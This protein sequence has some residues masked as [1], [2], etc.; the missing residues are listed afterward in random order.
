[1]V[2]GA[3]VREQGAARRARTASAQQLEVRAHILRRLTFGPFPGG[4]EASLAAHRST[5][6]VLDAMLAAKPAAFVPPASIDVPFKIND[7][8]VLSEDVLGNGELVKFWIKRMASDEV[9]IHDKMMWFWHTVFTT[10]GKTGTFLFLWRQLRTLH[11]NAMGNLR[12]LAKALV[13]DPAM[14]QFLNSD[15]SQIADPNENL[16]R[17]LMEL[18]MLGRGNYTEQD[19]R[20]AAIGLAGWGID[21]TADISRYLPVTAKPVATFLG[22]TGVFDPDSVVDQILAQPVAA[23]FVVRKMWHY[24]IGGPVDPKLVTEWSDAF[25]ASDYEIAPLVAAMV[26]SDAFL[27]SYRSRPRRGVEWL[28]AVLRILDPPPGRADNSLDFTQVDQLGQTPYFPP[29]VAGWPDDTEWLSSSTGY[30][31]SAYVATLP[32]RVPV[33]SPRGR[34]QA[35]LERCCLYDVS[36][37][38]RAA[39]DQLDGDLQG[40]RER[41]S[42]HMVKAVLM[43]PEFGLA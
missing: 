43:T 35:A 37:E 15:F 41:Q 38:T 21:F 12:T 1:M 13:I 29:N 17:E 22:K 4:P 2:R 32:S 25:R 24:F 5:A 30:T 34:V 20:A 36:P 8:R 19:V 18:F 28:A 33:M 3:S 39:L 7:V 27:Q 6:D 10:S 11:A 42:A 14:M 40:T 16:A 31:R 9:G 26:R 23:P